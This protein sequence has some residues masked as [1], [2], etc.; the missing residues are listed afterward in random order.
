MP[1][2]ATAVE[3]LVT[4]ARKARERAYAPYS[5]YAVG[6]AL[7]TEDGRVFEG[8]NVENAMYG[9][10]VCAERV[11]ILAAVAAGARRISAL[12]VV[13]QGGGTPCGVCRQVMAEFADPALPVACAGPEGTY[14]VLTLGA[15][16]PE[17]WTSAD[18]SAG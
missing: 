11:A 5:G 3:E 10:S 6:A 4:R 17:A 18:L 7:R 12:A 1:E 13:T 9:A 16:L 8:A 2:P 14:R 15:L